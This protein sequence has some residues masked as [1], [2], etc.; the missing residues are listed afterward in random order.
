M[1]VVIPHAA[2]QAMLLTIVGQPL[3][4]RLYTNNREPTTQ[5]TATQYAE[6]TF[7]GY[8][9][10]V[11]TSASWAVISGVP[12]G[13]QSTEQVFTCAS[14]QARQSCFGYFVTH[15]TG[16]QLL[17]AERFADGPYVIENHGAEI[18]ITANLTLGSL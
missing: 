15:H 5:D 1:P 12:R 3:A 14:A 11:L 2:Q 10:A 8:T 17:W 18:L 13:V 4:L 9:P 6:A 16:G 7:G